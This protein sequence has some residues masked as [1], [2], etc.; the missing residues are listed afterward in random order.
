MPIKIKARQV[1]IYRWRLMA[2]KMLNFIMINICRLY[3]SFNNSREYI[4]VYFSH[5]AHFLTNEMIIYLYCLHVQS[6]T[7]LTGSSQPLKQVIL[8]IA[9]FGQ[10]S[11]K[12]IH[13]RINIGPR[14]Y[15]YNYSDNLSISL[16]KSLR[17]LNER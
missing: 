11:T 7:T 9:K 10:N 13:N 3:D 2:A 16:R 5:H 4:A 6:A 17:S 14:L 15:Y 12:S 1:E 8:I